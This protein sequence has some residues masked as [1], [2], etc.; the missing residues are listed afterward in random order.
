[1]AGGRDR[2]SAWAIAWAIACGL[3]ATGC[4][5][6]HGSDVDGGDAPDADRMRCGTTTCGAGERCC[7]LCADEG[8]CVGAREPCPAVLCTD[9]CFATVDCADGS[10]C[11]FEPGACGGM[12]RCE[13]RPAACSGDCPG[14][15]GCDSNRYCNACDAA[16]S[17]VSVRHDGPCPERTFCSRPD[18]CSD[19]TFCDF[20]VSFACGG[21]DL[22]GRC[23]P[24]PSTCAVGPPVCGCDGALYESECEA[25]QAGTDVGSPE[26]CRDLTLA[27]ACDQLCG[28]APSCGGIP[29]S[30]CAAACVASLAECGGADAVRL[31]ECGRLSSCDGIEGCVNGVDCVR[32]F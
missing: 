5:V 27:R 11:V 18:D 15:C 32:G 1:M 2:G 30:E 10:T 14:V 22:F 4:Y 9:D 3:I 24:R 31:L 17:G 13:P 20:E 6:S 12:G 29:P 21:E 26:V 25:A 7:P 19:G 28:W 8:L 16:R 23:V